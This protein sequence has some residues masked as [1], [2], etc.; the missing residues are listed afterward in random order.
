[1]EGRS[2]GRRLDNALILAYWQDKISGNRVVYYYVG[3][4]VKVMDIAAYLE[5]LTDELRSMKN[6]IRNFI[7]NAHWQTD[8]EWKETIL[9]SVLRRYLP[10]TVDVGRGFIITKEGPSTQIDIL[11]YDTTK[12]VLFRDG[13]FVLITPDAV[14]G[15]IEVKTRVNRSELN[16]VLIKID[17]IAKLQ[18]KYPKSPMPFFGLFSY[19]EPDFDIHFALEA[20]RDVFVGFA[21]TP[22]HI[23]AFGESNFIRF[24]EC[25]PCDHRKLIYKWHA[26][27]L[28]GKAPAYFLH[29]AIA[30]TCQQSVDEN[31]EL[32]F[33]KEGKEPHIVD[34]IDMN[35]EL[36]NRSSESRS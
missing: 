1:V 21:V 16:G 10:K 13:D 17:A 15:V 36:T 20:I 29:N 25:D 4:R 12:P 30:F 24:W 22:I 34:T 14:I 11:I 3:Q 23:V 9:R 32:W 6:R 7:G 27:E 31:D 33:P 8:G 5:S 19:E 35:R 2:K 26:Y 18:R 28:T